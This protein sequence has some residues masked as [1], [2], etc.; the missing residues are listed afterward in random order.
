MI[1]PQSVR[2][3]ARQIRNGLRARDTYTPAGH[4]YS[5]TTLPSDRRRQGVW[6][7]SSDLP[8]IDLNGPEQLDFARRLAAVQP[9]FRPRRWDAA[10]SN[11][12]FGDIDARVLFAVIALLHPPRIIEVGS[13]YSTAIMLDAGDAMSSTAAITCIEPYP[14]RL[15]SLL[16]TEDSV[17]LLVKPVQDVP[18]DMFTSLSAGDLLFIDSTHVAKP[19]SDVLRLYLD[20]LPRL[21]A[22]VIVHVHDIFWPFSYRQEWLDEGRDW[23]E[24]YLLRALLTDSPSWEI[25]LFNDWLWTQHAEV[26]ETIAPSS[27][28]PGSIY[29]RRR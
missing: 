17:E 7:S 10:D 8:G 21:P 18:R 27:D 20:V 15:Q 1:V 14:E 13:G 19:G 23:T 12:M 4:F 2:S 11:T 26:G 29:L 24:A 5:P 22:G 25:L 6:D 28:R 9:A 3:V 16:R